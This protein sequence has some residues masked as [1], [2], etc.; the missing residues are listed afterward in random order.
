MLVEKDRK[1]GSDRLPTKQT[2]AFSSR[3]THDVGPM[4]MTYTAF[5]A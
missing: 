5:V 3:S 4:Q 1:T 2:L